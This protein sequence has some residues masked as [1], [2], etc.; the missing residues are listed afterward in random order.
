MSDTLYDDVNKLINKY[1][2]MMV[3]RGIETTIHRRSFK[4]EVE[5]YRPYRPG[6]GRILDILEYLLISKKIEKKKYHYIPN[7]Y[8]L[9]VLQVN[10]ISKTSAN[11]KIYKKYAFLVYRLSRPH[12]GDK[13]IKRQPKEQ[14]VIA[15]VEKRLKKLLKQAEKSTSSD[16]CRDTLW[17]ALRYSFSYKYGYLEYYCGKSRFFWEMLWLFVVTLPVLLFAIVNLIGSF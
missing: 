10:P 2:T 16:W 14:A 17:D 11:K 4:K 7:Y 1:N 12:Q 8:K 5:P 13:P 15:K 3:E 6:G 9:L